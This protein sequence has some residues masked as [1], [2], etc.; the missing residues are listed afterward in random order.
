MFFL[1]Q[2]EVEEPHSEMEKLICLLP[3][4]KCKGAKAKIKDPL[5]PAAL[6][7]GKG[8]DNGLD[9]WTYLGSLTT[10]PLLESVTWIVFKDSIGMSKEQVNILYCIWRIH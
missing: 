7:P 8:K 10:P 9:Y 2:Q 6:L 3:C 1:F 4:I 5:E